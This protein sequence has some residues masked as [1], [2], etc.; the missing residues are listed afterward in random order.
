MKA[1]MNPAQ[2]LGKMSW[3]KFSKGKTKNEISKEMS[4]KSRIRWNKAKNITTQK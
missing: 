4:E 2:E 3:K 1:N